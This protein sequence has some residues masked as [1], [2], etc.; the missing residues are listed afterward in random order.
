MNGSLFRI[1][2]RTAHLL[3]FGQTT[4]LTFVAQNNTNIMQPECQAYLYTKTED[5]HL[6]RYPL[7]SVSPD[8]ES[9][10]TIRQS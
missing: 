7:F 1:V 2:G 10:R 8:K 9:I 5:T 3:L 6:D 4:H